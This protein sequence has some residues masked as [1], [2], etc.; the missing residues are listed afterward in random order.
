MRRNPCGQSMV[1]VAVI[2]LFMLVFSFLESVEGSCCLN[3]TQF[4]FFSWE[5]FP[6]VLMPAGRWNNTSLT[7]TFPTLSVAHFVY[8]CCKALYALLNM[9]A[10][11][12]CR[13]AFRRCIPTPPIFSGARGG[14]NELNRRGEGN[15]ISWTGETGCGR[16]C[17]TP[18]PKIY[19]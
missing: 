6:I 4:C 3:S 15:V 14:I 17:C 5:H 9:W 8:I 10:R 11:M 19:G 16:Q 1:H 12:H 13:T 2:Y 18:A 7:V